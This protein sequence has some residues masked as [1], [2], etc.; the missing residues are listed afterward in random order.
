MTSYAKVSTSNA[1]ALQVNTDVERL[2][3]GLARLVL[4]IVELLR[5]LL[6]RQAQR[7]VLAG[8]LSA[9]EVE[10][11]GLA[12]MQIK[13]KIHEISNQFDLNSNELDIK[14]GSSITK[15]ASATKASL[16]DILDKLLDRGTVVGGQVTISV[17]DIDLI[18]LDLFAMLSL[19]HD[20][21][22]S[23]SKKVVRNHGS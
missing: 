6:E 3:N 17:A 9:E 12:F 15:N 7:R 14:V 4:T 10:R 2:Q 13:Q 22:E 5:Q 21:T 16:V 11:L 1:T 19:V 18:A 20:K 8:T 23:D